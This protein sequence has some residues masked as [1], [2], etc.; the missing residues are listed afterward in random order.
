M[1]KLPTCRAP[2]GPAAMVGIVA[3]ILL[4]P[5][6]CRNA[7]DRGP[8]ALMGKSAP[9]LGL[10]TL[11]HGRFFLDRRRNQAVVLLFWHTTCSTCKRQMVALSSLRASL[12][13]NRVVFATVC[14]DPQNAASVRRWVQ[15]V[16]LSGPTLLDHGE[17]ARRRY[18]VRVFPTTVVVA[19]G[20]KVALVREGFSR[21][22]I[23][24]LRRTLRSL[25]DG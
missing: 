24:Q 7:P 25:L 3:W 10:P 5:G 20:G 17:R 13:P 1:T 2:A 8:V 9:R 19:P 11:D 14:T 15:A 21:Q 16:R 4:C 23:P 22:V 12:D 6:A 18:G